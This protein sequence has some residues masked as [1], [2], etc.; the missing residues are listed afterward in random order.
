MSNGLSEEE[1]RWLELLMRHRAGKHLDQATVPDNV[2]HMLV[3]RKLV[4]RRRGVDLEITFDGI[5]EVLRSRKHQAE[6]L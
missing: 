1:L 6:I 2:V 3:K 4:D 5:R